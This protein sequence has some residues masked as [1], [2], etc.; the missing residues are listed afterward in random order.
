MKSIR[1]EI[2]L[3]HLLY[4]DPAARGIFPAIQPAD[5]GQSFGSRGLGDEI[6]DG[7][8][9]PQW[10]APPVRGNKG[11]QAVLDF[12]PLAGPRGKVAYR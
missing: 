1:M 4:G 5:H 10:L 2:Y 7:F 12:V 6:Y 3:F 8:I 11:K 9:V